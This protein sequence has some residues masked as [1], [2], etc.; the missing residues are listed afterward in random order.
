MDLPQKEKDVISENAPQLKENS[1]YQKIEMLIYME[2]VM[3]IKDLSWGV[4]IP[5]Y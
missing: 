3:Q 5:D 4:N 2:I 1:D